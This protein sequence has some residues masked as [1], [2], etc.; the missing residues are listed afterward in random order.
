MGNDQ[1]T[2]TSLMRIQK[3]ASRLPEYIAARMKLFWPMPV[4]RHFKEATVYR[5]AHLIAPSRE[6]RSSET[7]GK[8]RLTTADKETLICRSKTF[9]TPTSLR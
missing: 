3:P 5:A 9:R 2:L 6:R 1:T 4:G 8:P 7:M